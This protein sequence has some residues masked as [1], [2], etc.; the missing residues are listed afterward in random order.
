[1]HQD[2][3]YPEHQVHRERVCELLWPDRDARAGRNNLHGALH[4]ARRALAAAGAQGR[5]VLPLRDELVAIVGASVDVDRFE[6]AAATARASR[7]RDAYRAALGLYGGELLPEGAYEDWIEPR[8]RALREQHLGLLVE[9]A[10]LEHE[11]G[12][13]VAAIDLLRLALAEDELHEPATRLMMR[14]LAGAGRR[15]AALDAYQRL[16]RGLRSTLEADPDPETRRLY[17]ELLAGSIKAPS[18]AGSPDTRPEVAPGG[19]RHNL[20]H[21]TSSFIG[22]ERALAELERLL[23]RTRLLTLTGAG[24][25]GKTRL[26]EVVASRQIEEFDHGVWLADLA[27]IS[28]SELVPAAVAAVVGIELPDGRPPLEALIAQLADRHT[29]ILLDNCEHL[30]EA[31]AQLASETLRTCPAVRILATSRERLNIDDEVTWR[32]PSLALPDPARLPGPG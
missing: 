12:G 10:E 24:G 1:M 21:V 25:V 14:V 32:V 11:R 23:R 5:D 20:P 27:A 15:Q 29:L 16:R 7:D 3:G 28:E 4:A 9:L 26:A 18:E 30:V 8:R 2:L 19:R 13:S 31:C 22:R 17:R 6:A